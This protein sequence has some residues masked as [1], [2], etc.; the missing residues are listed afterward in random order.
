MLA[1]QTLL[2]AR[3]KTMLDPV[4]R[5]AAVRRDG[6]GHGARRDRPDRRR[7]RRRP[8]DRVRGPGDRGA[9]D[10]GPD[11]GLQHVDR[12]G[13]ARRD[14]R[15]RRHDVRLPRG[16]P[17]RPAAPP[18]SA[19]STRGARCAPTRTRRSTA[20][21]RSTSRRSSR[22]SRG[23]RT[24]AMVAPV[25]GVVPDPAGVRRPGRARGGRARARA[26]WASSRARR[27]QE[28]GDRPRLHRLVHELADRGPARRR[29]GRR[30]ASTVRRPV[31]AMVVPG[32]GE[33]EARRPRRRG[34]TASSRAPA[35]SGARRAAR[36]A[37][38]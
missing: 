34:S 37:S 38:A 28:I 3:P 27:S 21:S 13:R 15:A 19:R 14:G 9:L 26:T 16:P 17:G 31:R 35:S 24:R 10:G 1:T 18:G 32:L 12:G 8:R 4:R 30:T 6:E 20:S 22:R 25:D 36:C 29:G 5:R 2:Q 33:G 11:D 23:G 7:R